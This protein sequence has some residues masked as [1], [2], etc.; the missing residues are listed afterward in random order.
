[1][2]ALYAMVFLLLLDEGRKL[3]ISAYSTLGALCIAAV[4]DPE[5]RKDMYAK[6]VKWGFALAF[7]SAFICYVIFGLL[8][9]TN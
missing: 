7:A 2:S 4:R 1:L 3:D 8:K 5:V 6:M 9:V